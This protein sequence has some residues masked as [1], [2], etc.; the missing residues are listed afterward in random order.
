MQPF[1]EPVPEAQGG[2]RGFV[3]ALTIILVL[4]VSAISVS[5]MYTSK[6]GR[7]SSINY[8][9]KIQTFLASDGLV[10][11]LS[12]EL[13][14]GNGKKYVDSSRTGEI[15]GEVWTGIG[16]NDVESFMELTVRD[17]IPD[18]R[19]TSY[20]LGSN[21]N[22]DNYGVKWTG[23]II[24]PLSGNYTFYTRSDDESRFYLSTDHR[25]SN[26]SDDPICWLDHWVYSW[27]TGGTAV[28]KPTP[29]IGGNRYYFEY[30]H[31]EGGGFDV[32]QIGW[33]GPEYFSERPI[34]G[35][36]LSKYSSDS[37]WA[38]TVTVGNL[39]VRYQV[40]STGQDRYR[41]FTESIFTRPG[42]SRDTAFRTPL[43]QSISLKGA[44]VVPPNKL[45]LRVIHYDFRSDRS[46]SEF[47]MPSYQNGIIKDMV[48]HTLTNYT[49]TDAAFFGKARI[50]KP[51][52]YRATPNMNCGL[53]K[54][55]REWDW[56]QDQWEPD[57]SSSWHADNC[58]DRQFNAAGDNWRN[59]KYYDSL[60]FTLDLS[61]G[62]ST[63]VFSHMGNYNTGDP[64]TSFRGDPTMYFP[65]ILERQGE[66]PIGSGH[67]FG[68]CTEL[69]TNF[70]YQSG[71]KFEFTGDDDV[72]MFIDGKLVI[73]LGGMHPARSD[74]VQLD[75]LRDLR[76]GQTYDLDFFQCERHTNASSSRIVTNIKMVPPQGSPRAQWRRDYS[77]SD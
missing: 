63:Y 66:D 76:F 43:T 56:S 69:H 17:P 14:N 29:L 73:D 35:K 1:R 52:R 44:V 58:T 22:W 27:P 74:F 60:E 26:L 59:R 38:G 36:Y 10:T 21:L 30:Y 53:N 57:Y 12:Q 13:I 32:G 15:E 48:E 64:E 19:I 71:L 61:Q 54:W 9:N 8:K 11:L 5:T 50:P 28:S 41:I 51:S 72:W 2:S 46:N 68:F 25:K 3:L 23:W 18:H 7:M 37:T 55:F 70:I 40:Q 39:P 31:K 62:P 6:M 24:P 67:N 4:G 45:W 42:D 65:Q 33:D 34:T 20:Y 47:N 75:N 77:S 16:G 49:T